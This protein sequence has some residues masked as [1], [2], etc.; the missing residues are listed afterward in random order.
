MQHVIIIESEK[1]RR[2]GI[3]VTLKNY[4]NFAKLLV[5]IE[6]FY[7]VFLNFLTVWIFACFENEESEV[8]IKGGDSE[9]V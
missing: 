6:W 2:Y 1:N 7:K 3:H 4:K 5:M 8:C 9:V